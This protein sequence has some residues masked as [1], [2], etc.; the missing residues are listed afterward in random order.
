ML[1]FTVP[2][3]NIIMKIEVKF[4]VYIISLN[5]SCDNSPWGSDFFYRPFLFI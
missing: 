5:W 3:L 1:N 2:N 4:K